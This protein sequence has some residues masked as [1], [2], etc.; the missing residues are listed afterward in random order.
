MEPG[1]FREIPF[2]CPGTKLIFQTHCRLSKM[3]RQGKKQSPTDSTTSDLREQQ[4]WRPYYWRSGCSACILSL[5]RMPLL[6]ALY[7]DRRLKPRLPECLLAIVSMSF[8]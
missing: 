4:V 1:S 7:R 3:G 6:K 2:R 8:L 5:T